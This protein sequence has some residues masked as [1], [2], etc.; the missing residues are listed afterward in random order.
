MSDLPG[1][2]TS[3]GAPPGQEQGPQPPVAPH[4][5]SGPSGPRAGFW[6]RFAALLLDGL[7]LAVPSIIIVVALGSD[8]VANLITTLIGIAYYVYFEGGPTGQTLGKKALGIRVYDFRGGG[9]SIGHTRALV[10]YLVRIV[11]SI[12][13]F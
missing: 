4:A 13:L 9:G 10:R 2:T 5:G 6:Q 3:A 8:G 7:I 1:Q 11:S 12:P